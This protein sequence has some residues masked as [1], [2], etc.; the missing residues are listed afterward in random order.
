MNALFGGASKGFLAL[1]K[2][3]NALRQDHGDDPQ[4]SHRGAGWLTCHAE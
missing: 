1:L 4:G 3:Q 2:T